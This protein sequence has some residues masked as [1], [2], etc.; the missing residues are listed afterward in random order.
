MGPG[1]GTSQEG[2]AEVMRGLRDHS[3]RGGAQPILRKG[4]CLISGI[5]D[6]GMECGE[7]YLFS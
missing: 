2:S 4:E 6:Y 1:N 3:Q 7:I 5:E